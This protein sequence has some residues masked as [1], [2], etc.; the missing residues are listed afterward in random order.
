MS[1]KLLW[2]LTF[3]LPPFPALISN[4]TSRG[5]VLRAFLVPEK[6]RRGQPV[7]TI[8]NGKHN[9]Y[10]FSLHIDDDTSCLCVNAPSPLSI[11]HDDSPPL[12]FL[13]PAL[14]VVGVHNRMCV[15]VL[16]FHDINADIV[17]SSG[18]ETAKNSR[19]STVNEQ[20]RTRSEITPHFSETLKC[21]TFP[22]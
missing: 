21:K 12:I 22:N 9:N 15:K 11:I 6:E 1:D 4:Q 14:C 8:S 16:M 3:F 17:A 20:P 5:N 7:R 18:D 13:S 19:R 2:V 10:G